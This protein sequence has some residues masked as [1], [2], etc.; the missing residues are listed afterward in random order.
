MSKK[1]N[2]NL[3]EEK[4]FG[5][6]A[7][8]SEEDIRK[9]GGNHRGPGRGG[10]GPMGG[11]L[12]GEKPKDSKKTLLRVLKYLGSNKVYLFILVFIVFITSILSLA[13]PILSGAAIDAIPLRSYL[14]LDMDDKLD[15][16]FETPRELKVNQEGFVIN[17][18]DN[19][20]IIDGVDTN[21]LVT[22]E[23][24]VKYNTFI[25]IQNGFVNLY[26]EKEGIN[27]SS[28]PVYT[29]LSTIK[30]NKVYKISIGD[31]GI[32]TIDTLNENVDFNQ[33]LNTNKEEMENNWTRNKSV[34]GYG[35]GSDS[36]NDVFII[37][38]F[39]ASAYIFTAIFNF[40]SSL[41]S[42][43]LSQATIRKLRKDLF[44]NLVFL[45]IRYFD[46]HQHGD[47]MSR[48]SNDSATIATT[49]SQSVTSLLSSILTVIGALVVMIYKSPVLTLTCIVSLV[50]TLV[51]T[52]ILSKFMKKYFRL[53]R[54]LIGEIN[55]QVEEMVVGHKT[56][57][58][59]TKESDIKEEFNQT[60]YY[61][62]KYGFKANLFGGVMG[63]VMNVISNIGYLLVVVIGAL[64]V[65]PSS[66]IHF[67]G[68]G[69]LGQALSIGDIITFTN[70]SQQFNRPINTIANLYAQIQTSL[71]AAERVFSIM[72]E[73][74]EINE[75][76]VDMNQIENVGNI[77]FENVNFSYV[78]GE[79][80]LKD[81]NLEIKPGEKIALVGAT[82][83]G[84]TTIVNLLM[85]FYDVDSGSIKVGG[86]DIRD[87]EKGSLRSQ[88]AIV[89]QD[90]VLFKDTVG[91]NIRYGKL[92][93]TMDEIIHSADVSRSHKF[94]SRLHDGY[95]TMLTESGNN[96]SG[97]QRQLLSISRAV[98]A[99]PKIL[100]LDEATS[101][102]DT[103]T[104]KNIQ[105]ALANLMKNRTNVI[106]AH[107]LSTIKDADKI[108]VID[109]GRIV[110]IGRHDELLDKKGIYYNLYQTQFSGNAI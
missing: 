83:S 84:K 45:P 97:G 94:I 76:T 68:F 75:G 28:L 14:I 40:I 103:R 70:L 77:T 86:V 34:R 26:A 79:R 36:P 90:T 62:K 38:I 47:I 104:E 69:L 107:R 16:T 27:Q 5:K 87:I 11:R 101:S 44:E 71:A 24:E 67:L 91:N 42:V 31:S 43:R 72:D 95:D 66:S 51:A 39:L 81:F 106:I 10:G 22:N 20:W 32:W 110:E 55:A 56:V 1:T 60:S 15:L 29:K 59:F 23:D 92:D 30:N 78:E 82:G 2:K 54:S 65:S 35:I 102:V 48:M 9:G 85:R 57:K 89:L 58:A 93:A 12:F 41:V 109:K 52:H 25:I 88:I 33:I 108:V 100:I 17:V 63:P 61:L 49:I 105:D 80:V 74:H 96:L 6:Y 46:S 4:M 53:E 8:L 19:K 98:L 73:P 3:N 37:L 18:I 99:D 7:Q 64:L 50:L 21:V 13:T